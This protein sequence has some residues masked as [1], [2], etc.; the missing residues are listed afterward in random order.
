MDPTDTRVLAVREVGPDAVAIDLDLPAG[1]D[2]KPG[3]FLKVSADLDGEGRRPSGNRPQAGDSRTESGDG[4]REARFYTISSPDVDE[5]IEI[6]VEV[7]PEGTLGPW[8]AE[9]DP[10]DV[11]AIEGPYGQEFYDGEERVLVLAGGPGVGPA[12]GIAEA[13]LRDGNDVAVVYVDDAPIH[14]PRLAA[15]SAGGAD[16]FVLDSEQRVAA[17]VGRVL[18]ADQQIFV[19]GFADFIDVAVSAIEAAGGDPGTAKIENFG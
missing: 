4:E 12:V 16:V 10:G 9:R 3:Q 8:L 15:A 1:F 17:A 18:A 6:T 5:R 11:V 14:E 2:A 19:Y 7:D 13:A